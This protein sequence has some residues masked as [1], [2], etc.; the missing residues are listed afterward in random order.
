MHSAS[1]VQTYDEAHRVYAVFF[2]RV[3][4]KTKESS[5][6]TQP[7]GQRWSDFASTVRHDAIGKKSCDLETELAKLMPRF[8]LSWAGRRVVCMFKQGFS[9]SVRGSSS[10]SPRVSSSLQS[11]GF[12]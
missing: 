4:N 8:S 12:L 3:A 11:P 9:L 7:L 1:I 2:S 10:G 6:T 5:L